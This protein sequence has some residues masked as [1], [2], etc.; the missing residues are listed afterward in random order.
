MGLMVTQRNALA[1]EGLTTKADF[2]YFEDEE[3]NAALKNMRMGLPGLVGT[4]AVSERCDGYGTMLFYF[5]AAV[6]GIPGFCVT[7]NPSKFSSHLLTTL[8]TANY[9]RDTSRENNANNMHFQNSLHSFK[10]E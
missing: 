9:Y 6:P 4:P 8:I 10:T 7:P 3:L 5:F 2:I 1:L